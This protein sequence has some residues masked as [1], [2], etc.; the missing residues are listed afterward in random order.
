[1]R[2]LWNLF[3][4]PSACPWTPLWEPLGIH[5]PLHVSS[6]ASPSLLALPGFIR[7]FL[8]Q[9]IFCTHASRPHTNPRGAALFYACPLPVARPINGLSA[10]RSGPGLLL[11][12]L[13]LRWDVQGSWM[14]LMVCP[15]P[16]WLWLINPLQPLSPMPAPFLNILSHTALSLTSGS[17]LKNSDCMGHVLSDCLVLRQQISPINPL[18]LTLSLWKRK[19]AGAWNSWN[20]WGYSFAWHGHRRSWRRGNIIRTKKTIDLLYWATKLKVHDYFLLDIWTLT[21]AA[22]L[23]YFQNDLI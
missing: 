22:P 20:H 21:A 16:S 14:P 1:M 19:M 13:T 18:W 7:G 9:W 15:E 8:C 3:T 6:S 12:L 17:W 23:D 11:L 4:D 2:I 5:H 10:G